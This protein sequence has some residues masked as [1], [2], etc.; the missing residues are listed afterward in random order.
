LA[1]LTEP[2]DG[3]PGRFRIGVRLRPNAGVDRFD[4]C[5]DGLLLARVAARPVDG[6]ANAALIA[7]VSDELG[8]ARRRVSLVRGAK[9]RVKLLEVDGVDPALARSRWPGVDV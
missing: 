8:I 4:G 9:G 7:L 2:A 1:D 5:V 3:R 6:A